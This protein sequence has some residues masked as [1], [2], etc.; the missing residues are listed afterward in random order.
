MVQDAKKR[1]YVP[2]PR[3]LKKLFFAN[4]TFFLILNNFKMA[5]DLDSLPDFYRRRK[6]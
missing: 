3:N 1:P 4:Y 5:W 6:K 2:K